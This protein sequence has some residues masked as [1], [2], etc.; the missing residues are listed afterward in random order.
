MASRPLSS[1]HPK[2]A[3]ASLASAVTGIIIWVY[4]SQS[5]NTI[6]AAVAV[7]FTTV[8]AFV[9]G[10]VVPS[11]DQVELPVDDSNAPVGTDPNLPDDTVGEV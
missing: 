4:E 9:L 5:H 2:V 6:P 8:A 11:D 10:Y 7:A 3:I 1:V